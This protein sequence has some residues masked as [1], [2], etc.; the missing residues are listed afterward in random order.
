MS[1][2]RHCRIA[3]NNGQP[4]RIVFH[5]AEI[6]PLKR[7]GWGV[8]EYVPAE[9]L[10][11]AVEAL[12]RIERVYER[13]MPGPKDALRDQVLEI[14]ARHRAGGQYDDTPTPSKEDTDA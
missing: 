3:T 6:E 12:A 7:A 14:I 10:R 1:V 5:P 11:G 13:T 8:E 2:I 4:L 9:Q